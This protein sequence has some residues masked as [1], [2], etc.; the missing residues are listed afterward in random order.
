[1]THALLASPPVRL[2]RLPTPLRTPY[3]LLALVTVFALLALFASAAGAVD[4]TNLAAIGGPL[5]TALTQLA[6]LTPG[7]KALV[8]T[9]A[10]VVALIIL[11]AMK[12]Y[13]IV[14]MWAGVMIFAAV[15]LSIGGAIIGAVI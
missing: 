14:L 1:M 11:A 10:F 8:G 3:S 4:L 15:G 2:A 7:I 12:T 13:A 5:Q 6:D 9:L